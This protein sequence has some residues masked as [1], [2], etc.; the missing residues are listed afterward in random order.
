ML[1]ATTH[2]QRRA[3]LADRIDGPILLV[4][5]GQRPRNLPAVLV[6]FRQDSTFLYFTGCAMA[7]AALLIEDDGRS[8][9]FLPRPADDDPLWHGEVPGFADL[10][11]TLGVDAVV[12]ADQLESTVGD[13]RPRTLAIA[14]LARNRLAQRLAGSELQFGVKHGDD[15]LVDAVIAM[16]RT[17]SA[18]ELDQLRQAASH[19]VAAHL[20]VMRA[21][22][23]GAHERVLT[24]LF[25]GVLAARGCAPGYGTIL[26]QRGEVLHND[27]HDLTLEAGGLLL[28][29][30]GG[31]V[32][33]GYGADVTRTLPVSGSY[34]P[35]Q[36]AAYDAVLEAQLASIAQCR[37]GTPYRAVH[38]ASCAVLARFLCDERLLTCSPEEALERHAHALF[39][40]H[41]VGHHLGMDVHDLEN[42][43]DLPSYPDGMSRPEPF[44]TCYL[45]LNLPLEEGWVVTIEPGFYVV[46]AI[47][48]DATLRE[49]FGDIVDYDRTAQWLGFGGIRTEDDVAILAEGPEVLTGAL[50]KTAADVEAVIGTGPDASELLSC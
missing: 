10:Q 29:D 36:R 34:T 4:G 9:L 1:P 28:I 15:A 7:D 39:F 6:P 22:R 23:P 32:A 41:G 20:A 40:P 42:F 33:S 17:K 44:G 2:R 38:D 16:R 24:A 31:E 30:G 26:T 11:A 13:R 3:A 5:H 48:R 18:E 27:R 12:G 43:G 35:R 14:D 50:P 47:L 19:T 21:C 37:P 49:R 45:R 25:E 46:P 8:T